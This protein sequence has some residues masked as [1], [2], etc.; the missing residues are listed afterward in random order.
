[1]EKES[2]DVV[3]KFRPASFHFTPFLAPPKAPMAT[4]G[5]GSLLL[6][7]S[8]IA[9]FFLFL[10]FL[11]SSLSFWRTW[12]MH[13]VGIVVNLVVVHSFQE[14]YHIYRE[15]HTTIDIAIAVLEQEGGKEEKRR[16][17]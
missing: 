3:L 7:L 8:L 14:F 13:L 10:I 4:F 2:L 11:L 17:K 1:M 5:D 6:L 15:G 9:M 16:L 12:E